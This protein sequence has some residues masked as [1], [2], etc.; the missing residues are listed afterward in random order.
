MFCVHR[1]ALPSSCLPSCHPA[2]GNAEMLN[3]YYA[4]ADQDDGLQRRCYWQLDPDREHTVL[5][6]YLCSTSSRA[7]GRSGAAAASEAA[8]ARP[9]RESARARRAYSPAATTGRRGS[10]TKLSPLA[11]QGSMGSG[12]LVSQSSDAVSD[13]ALAGGDFAVL[14][15]VEGMTL[16]SA[17]Q[18]PS[19]SQQYAM[20]QQ[21]L[22]GQLVSSGSAQ[23]RAAAAAAGAASAAADALAAVSC[24]PRTGSGN[25][26]GVDVLDPFDLFAAAEAELQRPHPGV[27]YTG[28]RM[29]TQMA[30][31][32]VRCLG[33]G[34]VGVHAAWRV[35]VAHVGMR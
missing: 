32:Q 12:S 29:A 27:L 31:Q 28:Q 5:V 3:C 13:A 2:V 8:E 11:T 1:R 25:L 20:Q 35:L 24:L 17:A 22:V 18:L 30:T 34:V 14:P 9:R 7:G 10:Q 15:L 4:H 19:L 26:A 6:H 23:Q 33:C 21:M 16:Q